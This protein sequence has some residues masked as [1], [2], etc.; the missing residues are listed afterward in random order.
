[1]QTAKVTVCGS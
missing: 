1:M